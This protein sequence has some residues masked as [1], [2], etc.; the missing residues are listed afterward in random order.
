MFK[1]K[2]LM[3]EHLYIFAISVPI[4]LHSQASSIATFNDLNYLDWSEQV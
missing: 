4:A 2:V 1:F 3:C